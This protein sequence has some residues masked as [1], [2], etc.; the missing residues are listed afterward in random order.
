MEDLEEFG[1]QISIYKNIESVD[2]LPYHT[3]G[4]YKYA[5]LGI[6]NKLAWVSRPTQES[7]VSTKTIFEKYFKKVLVR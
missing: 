1:R 2:I 6:Q 4:S 5:E 3:L 7:I